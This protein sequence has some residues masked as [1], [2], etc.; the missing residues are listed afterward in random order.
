[1]TG[2][3]LSTMM[4]ALQYQGIL[5]HEKVPQRRGTTICL[6][7]TRHAVYDLS[8]FSLLIIKYGTH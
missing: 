1:M 8:S 3:K 7:M 6:D 4:Q 5:E 2:A